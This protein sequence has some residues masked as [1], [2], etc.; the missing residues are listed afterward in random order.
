MLLVGSTS[1]QGDDFEPD[2]S[3]RSQLATCQLSAQRK[4]RRSRDLTRTVMMG[5]LR[6]LA[7]PILVW[8]AETRMLA[9]CQLRVNAVCVDSNRLMTAEKRKPG[10]RWLD[11]YARGT[12]HADDWCAQTRM[13]TA[14]Q[15]R[16]LSH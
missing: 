5:C 4:F 6:V 12:R 16:R 10:E 9:D 11:C 1:T 2:A 14:A 7:I 15:A 8:A 3:T 13:H